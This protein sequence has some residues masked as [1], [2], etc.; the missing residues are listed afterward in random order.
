MLWPRPLPTGL[1]VISRRSVD[2]FTVSTVDLFAL[3]T[4]DQYAVSC[5]SSHIRIQCQVATQGGDATQ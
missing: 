4:R 5:R 3:G 2:L 1:F